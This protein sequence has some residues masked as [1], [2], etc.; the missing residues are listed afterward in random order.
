[1]ATPRRSWR[2]A[3]RA[4]A[5]RIGLWSGAVVAIFAG[6]WLYS[7]SAL[8]QVNNAIEAVAA[9]LLQPFDIIGKIGRLFGW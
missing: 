7:F 3:A 9:M 2:E 5:G 4:N 8:G 1:V 6:V